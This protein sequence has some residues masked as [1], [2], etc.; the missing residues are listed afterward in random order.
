MTTTIEKVPGK[1]IA[2]LA[3]HLES[4]RFAPPVSRRDFAEKVLLSGED[5]LTD[6]AKTH[7][8]MGGTMTGFIHAMT[9]GGPWTPVP[10][11][12]ADIGA[13]GPIAH[14]FY[15]ELYDEMRRGLEAAM[16]LDGIYFGQHGAAVTTEIPDPDGAMFAMAREIVGPDVPIIS[17]L[18]LHGNVS[19]QMVAATDMLIAYRTNPHVDQY[20]RGQEAASAMRE[21]LAG[22]KPE[23]AFIRLPLVAPQVRQLTAVGPYGAAIDKGQ[24]FIDETVMNVSILGGFTYGDTPYN[25]MSFLVTTRG[26]RTRAQSVCRELAEDVWKQHEYFVPDLTPL[27]ECVARAVACGNDLSLPPVIIAD[28]ADNPGGGGRGNTTYLL[29]AL[30]AAGAKGAILGVMNDAALAKEAHDKGVGATFDAL[31]NRAESDKYSNNYSHEAT[32]LNLSDGRFIGADPGTFANLQLDLGP[33]AVLQVGTVTVVVVSIREQCIDPNFFDSFGVSV[34][35]ARSVT[36]KSRGHFR[37]GFL[38]YF[39]PE[40][41]LECD[42]PGLTSPNLVNFDWTG[43]TRPIFPLDPDTKWTPPDW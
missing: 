38:P 14:D 32:V 30:V 1:R 4:N 43:F 35:Q 39:P 20:E 11:V 37:A 33:T 17:T 42:A 26:D 2:L 7:S 27:D 16:P 10:I 5:I 34:A 40:R 3:L 22:L 18:D 25:G 8:R 29:K 31:F 13:A 12:V 24:T 19:D 28:V 15:L 6:A 9:G 23:T 36:V 21:L 41:V